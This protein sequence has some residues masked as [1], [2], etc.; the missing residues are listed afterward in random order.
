MSFNSGNRKSAEVNV[1]F[2]AADPQIAARTSLSLLSNSAPDRST[3]H[4]FVGER[5]TKLVMLHTGCGS[6]QL[7]AKA[8]LVPILGSHHD[9][10]R[11]LD[12]ERSKVFASALNLLG[13]AAGTSHYPPNWSMAANVSYQVACR[14][15]MFYDRHV[16]E[17]RGNP[18]G[19]N[20]PICI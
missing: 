7:W 18:N 6:F 17:T 20:Y 19:R 1:W 13:E 5:D 8:E 16:I 15:Q 11:G 4:E 9:D 14:N 12:K 10:L 2:P 3:L